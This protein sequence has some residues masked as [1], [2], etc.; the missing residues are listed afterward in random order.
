MRVHRHSFFF[1]SIIIIFLFN[2]LGP[3]AISLLQ[4]SH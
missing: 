4:S 3:Q 2:Q 1:F